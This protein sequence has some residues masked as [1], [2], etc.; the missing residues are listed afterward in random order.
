MVKPW[1]C[2][3]WSE[4]CYNLWCENGRKNEQ[5][6]KVYS[7]EIKRVTVFPNRKKSFNTPIIIINDNNNNIRK[8]PE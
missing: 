6:K 7:T 8:P 5:I 1:L 2:K 3:T 4:P